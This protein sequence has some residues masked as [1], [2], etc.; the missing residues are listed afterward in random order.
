MDE[1]LRFSQS[2]G[3]RAGCQALDLPPS[4]LYREKLRRERPAMDPRPRPASPRA[5]SPPEK[6]AVVEVLHSQRFVDKAPATVWAELL[7]EGR[8][9]CSIRTMYR[10][11][12]QRLEVKE[13]RRQR[14]HPQYAK[15]ELLA[16]GPNQCWSW[17]ITKLKGPVKW[18]YYY[19]YVVLDIFSRYVVGWM[20]ATQEN[21]RLA[22]ALIAQSYSKQAIVSGDLTL[23]ADRGSSMSSK[24]LALLLADLGVTKSHSRPHVCDDN[25]YSEA[26]FKTLKYRPE[27]PARFGTIQQAR[28]FCREFFDCI[29]ATIAIRVSACTLPR[30][31]TTS[32]PSPH[33]AIEPK[34]WRPPMHSSRRDF[35]MANPFLPLFQRRF[36]STLPKRRTPEMTLL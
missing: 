31:C 24:A 36:G 9:L 14:R 20:V 1:A 8:Y 32:P 29:T 34:H 11:L 17:D 19:L 25:P 33:V 6:E 13:R 2:H 12:S 16:T 4:S 23:H 3:V 26:Q 30:T 27:F 28:T 7:D 35:P 15:P 21:S 18:S 5:L 10:I 22:K